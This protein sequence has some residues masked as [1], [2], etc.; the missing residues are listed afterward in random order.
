MKFDYKKSLGQNFLKDKNIIKKI[1][2]SI[3]PTEEDL[4]I[5]IGPG[6]GALTKELVKKKSEV[7]CFEID[8][9]LKEILEQI[10]S[11]KLTIIYKDFLSIKINEYIDQNKYKNLYFVGNLPYYITTAI[12]NKIVKESN[13]YEIT[14]MVQKEV[15]DRFSAKPKTKDY[16]SISIFLQYNFDIERVCN[17]SKTCFEPVPKVDS[18][19]IKFKRNKKISANDEEKFYKLIKDS[20]TQKRKNLKNNLKG[21]DLNK[22]QMI[23]KKYDKDLTARA[24]Q[25]SI[26][27]FIDISNNI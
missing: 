18:S 12:I 5:E 14:I 17:V 11:E 21:Y 26:E 27:E 25:L 10:N 4:I 22:I 19:V 3:N 24:E 16:S 23:L 9:R 1:A 15:A 6:A 7:I 13:P 20:F 2:D 8:T